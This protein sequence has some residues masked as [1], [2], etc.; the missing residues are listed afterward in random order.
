LHDSEVAVS[1]SRL[2]GVVVIGRRIE[3]RVSKQTIDDVDV[4]VL[5][6]LDKG[7]VYISVSVDKQL[8]RFEGLLHVR[9]STMGSVITECVKVKFERHL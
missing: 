8:A 9:Q 1:S 3:H 6:G 2:H 4:A 5:S 7:A